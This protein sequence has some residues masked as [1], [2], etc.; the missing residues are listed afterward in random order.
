MNKT[1]LSAGILILGL[2]GAAWGA[3]PTVAANV[4]LHLDADSVAQGDGTAVSSWV[5][6]VGPSAA[7]TTASYQP[8]YRINNINGH[9]TV[10]FDQLD[11]HMDLDSDVPDS[12]S[13]FVV[14]K[15]DG[16][17]EQQF[18]ISGSPNHRMGHRSN[19]QFVGEDA[20]GYEFTDTIDFHIHTYY[21]DGYE[22]PLE[23]T[24]EVANW[25]WM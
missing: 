8:T 14:A 4:T 3:L 22:S 17:G 23:M 20:N 6:A 1:V 18:Y 11:D 7:Q 24:I 12:Y 13:V 2:S 16:L 25:A 15:W 5:A 9:A 10:D 19:R 21:S